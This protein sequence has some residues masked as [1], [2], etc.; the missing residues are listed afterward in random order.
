MGAYFYALSLRSDARKYT[1]SIIL[2]L[3]L[4]NTS[5]LLYML[6]IRVVYGFGIIC[7]TLVVKIKAPYR[8]TADIALQSEICLIYMPAPSGLQPSG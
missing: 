5:G 3:I 7:T 2:A 6:A 8:G 4:V 1:S